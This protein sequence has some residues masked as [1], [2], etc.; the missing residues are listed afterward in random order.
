MSNVTNYR[1][2]LI[3]SSIPTMKFI[4]YNW[5]EKKTTIITYVQN[6]VQLAGQS[7]K[8]QKL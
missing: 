5:A 4:D 7:N 3:F 8:N 6:L 2:L 1:M